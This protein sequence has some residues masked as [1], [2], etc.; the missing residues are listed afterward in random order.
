MWVASSWPARTQDAFIHLNSLRARALIALGS[1][2]R[3]MPLLIYCSLKRQILVLSF[4]SMSLGAHLW[5]LIVALTNWTQGLFKTLLIMHLRPLQDALMRGLGLFRA[6]SAM[7][8]QYI[9]T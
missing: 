5:T 2:G 9:G 6:Q 1:G 8:L 7:V 4:L 3:K